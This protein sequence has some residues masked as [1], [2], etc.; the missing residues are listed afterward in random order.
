MTA[1]VDLF[2]KRGLVVG[3]ANDSSIA[4]GCA[5]AIRAASGIERFD[6]HIDTVHESTPSRRLVNIA[7]VGR[8]AASWEQGGNASVGADDLRR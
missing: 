3:I 1:I 8:I 7:E 5:A 4:A 6:E 2:G